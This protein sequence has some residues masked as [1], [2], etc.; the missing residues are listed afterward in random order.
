[1]RFRFI[2]WVGAAALGGAVLLSGPAIS[3]SGDAARADQT[4]EQRRGD[5]GKDWGWLGLLGLA[6]LAGLRRKRQDGNGRYSARG[7]A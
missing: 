3:Q 5:D 4:Q 7:T 6:G 2:K 1:M